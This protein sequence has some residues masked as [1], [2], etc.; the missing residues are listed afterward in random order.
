MYPPELVSPWILTVC[1]S[2]SKSLWQ[3]WRISCTGLN[4]GGSGSL[5][6]NIIHLDQEIKLPKHL[7]LKYNGT[8]QTSYL[9]PKILSPTAEFSFTETSDLFLVSSIGSTAVDDNGA[10]SS[11]REEDEF[12]IFSDESDS[13][14]ILYSCHG[15]MPRAYEYEDLP[16]PTYTQ[17]L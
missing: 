10:S 9:S 1:L 5:L 16:S 6:K 15:P 13:S 17:L 3:I 4:D 14:D 11:S 12:N 7:I 8:G 2:S